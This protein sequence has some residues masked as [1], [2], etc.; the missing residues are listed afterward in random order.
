MCPR[1]IRFSEKAVKEI[2][3]AARKRGF[4][5]PSA[6]IRYAVDQELLGREE[7]IINAEERLVATIEQVRHA[8]IRL[9]RAQQ[10]LFALVN[11]L[12]KA[13]LTCMPEPAG[14]A[15]EAAVAQGTSLARPIAEE[16]RPVNGRLATGHAG[17][18]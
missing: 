16:C 5:S 15:L 2:D 1:A 17:L 6:F 10:A 12:A 7:D 14:E 9:A 4:S 3:E 11:S 18:D 13:M 8:V